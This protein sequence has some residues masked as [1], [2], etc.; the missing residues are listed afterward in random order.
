[1]RY[2]CVLCKKEFKTR[3][4]IREHV[5]TAHKDKKEIMITIMNLIDGIILS[6]DI[7]DNN[8]EKE[9]FAKANSLKKM[10]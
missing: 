6:T 1:M 7:K 2:K 10:I 5:L 3:Y 8:I 9:S 4:G